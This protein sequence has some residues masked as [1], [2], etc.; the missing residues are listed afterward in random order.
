VLPP[1]VAHDGRSA[2]P[3]RSFRKRVL[4]LDAELIDEALVGA[5]VDCST[6]DDPDLR[7]TVSRF[8]AS[9]GVEGD[10]LEQESLLALIVEGITGTLAPS[11]EPRRHSSEAA[12]A[13]KSTLDERWHQRLDLGE[14]AAELGWNPTHLIRCFTRQ[15]GLPPHR[16]IISRRIDEAR[17]RL[18]DGQAPASVASNVGFHDQAHLG[19][20][21]KAHLGVTPGN[22]RRSSPGSA[23]TRGRSA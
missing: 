19:R 10:D 8:H 21:F 17:R 13:L 18:L 2:H 15:F 3:G 7:R 1:F 4:Y 14:V 5:A 9:L 6:I 20:H 22:Y 23:G 11:A 12:D 16:Y